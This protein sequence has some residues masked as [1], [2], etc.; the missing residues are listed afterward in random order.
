MA[1]SSR[2]V[3][4]FSAAL[5]CGAFAGDRGRLRRRRAFVTISTV[6]RA[7]CEDTY[8]NATCV[9]G[10]PVDTYLTSGR[11]Q[12]LSDPPPRASQTGFNVYGPYGSGGW[13]C[14]RICDDSHET[15]TIQGWA[16]C[17]VP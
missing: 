13:N 2:R 17:A 9:A 5:L 7:H 15:Q 16:F 8:P 6:V 14:Q 1:P 12:V 10:C 4:L 3:V 11:C